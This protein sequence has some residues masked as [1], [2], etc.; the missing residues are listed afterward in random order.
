MKVIAAVLGAAVS[1]LLTL[2][3]LAGGTT[4]RAI[5]A[6][7]DVSRVLDT[8][9]TLESGGDY[10]AKAAHASASGAYQI[11]DSTWAAWSV[12]AGI[13][14]P[15]AHASDAPPDVQDAVAGY[16]VR[17]ILD[18]YHDVSYV[19]L[20]WYYPAAIGNPV[21]MDSVPAPEAG[22]TLTPRQYQTRWMD[23]YNSK[24]A[25]GTIVCG[26]L[27]DDGQW[28]LPLDRSLLEANPAGVNAPH[29]DYPA[30]DF[31]VPVGTPV[32]AVHAGTVTHV[33]TWTGNCYADE[34]T[35]IEKCGTGIT[36][37]DD[38]GAHWIYCHASRLDVATGDHVA[39]GQ[40]I[41]RSGNTGHSS[42][43]HLHLGI[44]VNGVDVCPQPLLLALLQSDPIPPPDA[45]PTAGCAS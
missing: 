44:R 45:L 2:P 33:S 24:A 38:T 15:Y 26:P 37:Q 21:L 3:L 32:Y 8:I 34:S 40:E 36:I 30:W 20:V 7:G 10:T 19:P 29:H 35:C 6:C 42:G 25:D 14:T 13:T 23:V 39:A 43:P 28:S 11:I 17:L 16:H 12:D 9:R 22:N 4:G 1:G 27:S 5:A 41:M 31:G 18:L